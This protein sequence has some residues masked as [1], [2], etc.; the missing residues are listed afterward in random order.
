MQ[1][2]A[3]TLIPAAAAVIGAAVAVNLRPGPILVS[4]IQH[5]AAGVVFAAAAGE[6]LPDLKHAGSP[7]A[8]LAGGALGV[9][10]MLLVKTLGKRASGPV[11]LMAVTGIDILVDGLVLGIAF[12]AG[13]KAGI[14]LTV[15]LT[16]EV[17]F[18]GLTVANEL[19]AA[20]TSKRKVVGMTAGLVVLLPLGALLGGPV[21]TLSSPIQ[22]AFLSF[23][24]IALLY[25]VTEEL[26][27]EAHE[28]ED[29]PWV[30]AMFFAGFLLLL[31]LDQAIA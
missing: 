15:A 10:A 4:A 21:A 29:R 17:L 5:F 14:L 7:L 2:W 27:V 12:A 26:L 30:T 6:I 9:A 1:A 25:L 19:G 28:T 8:M 20:G 18:L 22:A 3:Y 16:I 24:L 31:M 13:A 23:G 11:G